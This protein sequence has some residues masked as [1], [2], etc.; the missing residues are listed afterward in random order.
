MHITPSL[1]LKR[2]NF[3]H[4]ESHFYLRIYGFF[5]AF[6]KFKGISVVLLKYNPLQTIHKLRFLYNIMINMF[7]YVKKDEYHNP[8][9]EYFKI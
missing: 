4:S 8:R 9:V 3:I 1:T 2:T 5:R 6:K 7:I